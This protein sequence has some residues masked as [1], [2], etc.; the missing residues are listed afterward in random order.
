MEHSASGYGFCACAQ[1]N[2]VLRRGGPDGM[3]AGMKRSLRFLAALC[4]CCAARAGAA[5]TPIPAELPLPQL[6]GKLPK[7]VLPESSALVKSAAHENTFWSLNDSGNPA[8]IVAVDATGKLRAR[9]AV[10]GAKNVDWEDAAL[11][12]QNRL[13]A[14][15][16]GDNARGR[17][18]CVLYR[19]PEPDPAKP[20]VPIAAE[21]VQ[22]FRFV[23][24]KDVGPQDAEALIVRAGYAYVFTKEPERTRCFRIA[25]GD[26]PP[27]QSAEAEFVA[28]SQAIAT[29]TG[30][31][32]SPDGKRLALLTYTLL[33]TFEWPQPLEKN[34][35]DARKLPL[36]FD[37]VQRRRA[38]VLGQA[39]GLAWD[40]ADLLISTEQMKLLGG[41]NLWRVAGATKP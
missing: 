33:L 32:L 21:K 13:I 16:I 28:A 41:C 15:D 14:A 22:A 37:G 25:L 36:P 7:D 11:D 30:A 20:E 1:P 5:E 26:Q 39:E 4:A 3:L 2:P 9:F 8:E 23:Y 31:S 12:E 19:F 38:V 6:A 17:R 29:V 10:P 35:G 18:E 24:P 34:A 27:A 40:G